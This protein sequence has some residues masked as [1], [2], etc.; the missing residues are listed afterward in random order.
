MD[1]GAF[2]SSGIKLVEMEMACQH[3]TWLYL[4]DAY[5]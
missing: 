1:S 2:S 5:M 3:I 4:H